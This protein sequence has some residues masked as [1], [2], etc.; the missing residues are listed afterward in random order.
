MGDRW[1]L[2]ARLNT[3]RE[4]GGVDRIEREVEEGGGYQ[5]SRH[6]PPDGGK[7]T[8]LS[9]HW[10][11]HA[12]TVRGL[13]LQLAQLYHDLL[14]HRIKSGSANCSGNFTFMNDLAEMTL[15]PA[16]AATS[17]IAQQ[18]ILAKKNDERYSTAYN[19]FDRTWGLPALR[20]C[21]NIWGGR[22]GLPVPNSPYGLCGRK[23]TLTGGLR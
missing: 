6:E 17:E 2:L 1:P 13:S 21:E 23:A 12:A 16:F 14:Q 9:C 18:D 15:P 19:R 20:S 5:S 8:R 3:C 10:W 22:P 4:R 11:L 7:A